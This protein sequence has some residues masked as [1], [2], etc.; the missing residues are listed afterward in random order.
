MRRPL[1][2]E[3]TSALTTS[4]HS[5]SINLSVSNYLGALQGD[6]YSGQALEGLQKALR[7]NKPKQDEIKLLRAASQLHLQR[8]EW[9]AAAALIEM[10]AQFSG[11]KAT[12]EKVDLWNQLAELRSER[13][14]D[15]EGALE[16]YEHALKLSPKHAN[17]RQAQDDLRK[18]GM[19][20]QSLVEQK[21]RQ[22]QHVTDPVEKARLITEI[23]ALLQKFEGNQ[24]EAERYFKEAIALNSRE[25]R[26]L[27]LYANLL[28]QQERWEELVSLWLN[29]AEVTRASEDKALFFEHAARLLTEKLQQR[30][31]AMA[32]YERVIAHRPGDRDA[33]ASLAEWF[34]EREAWDD[35]VELY[36]SALRSGAHA[37]DEQGALL[38]VGMI[39]WRKRQV[40]TDAEPYFARL[41]KA[42]PSHPAVLDFY[43]A[44]L[45][46]LPDQPRL[47]GILQDAQRAAVEP[48]QRLSLALKI[49][50]IAGKNNA[51]LDRSIDAWKVVLQ[52]D[53]TNVQAL[54]ALKTLYARAER[55]SALAELLKSML[56][57]VPSEDKEQQLSVLTELLSLY[58][59]RLRS[60]V[61]VAN[62]YNAI[63][64]IAPEDVEALSG[65][66]GAYERMGRWND[67][68]HVL[69]KHAEL[70]S[71]PGQKVSLLKSVADLS[72]EHSANLNQA[73][74]AL[75]QVLAVSSDEDVVAKLRDVFIKKRAWKDLYG[76][77]EQ[78]ADSTTSPVERQKY[79][80]EMANLAG[81]KLGNRLQAIALWKQILH[82]DAGA[83]DA[84]DAIEKLAEQEQDW[85]SLAEVLERRI[86]AVG[87]D[88]A[89]V[90]FLERLGVVYA[91]HLHAAD[92]ALSTWQRL[93]AIDPQSRRA[94][95]TVR[96]ALQEEQ[97]WDGLEALYASKNDWEG[98][99]DVLGTA[100]DRVSDPAIKID[101]SLRA[102]RVYEEK[103]GAPHRA[104]RSYERILSVDPD[105]ELAATALIPIYEQEEKWNRLVGVLRILLRKHEGGGSPQG[106]VELLRKLTLL[107]LDKLRDGE[108][109]LV[110]ALEAFQLDPT[111]RSIRE[112]LEQ[113]AEL[114]QQYEQLVGAYQEGLSKLT[115]PAELT[116]L[117]RRLAQLY[118]G[119]LATPS[120]AIPY[121]R[122]VADA[123]SADSEA[124]EALDRIYRNEKD[125]ESLKD[126][127]LRRL[128]AELNPERKVELLRELAT[129]EE[130]TLND[131]ES[132]AERFREILALDP[133]DVT[134]IIDLE[135]LATQSGRWK[136]LAE[137]LERHVE[138]A[139]NEADRFDLIMQR[140]RVFE[141]HL[142]EQAAA[143]MA[144]N[145]A[146]DMEPDHPGVLSALEQLATV[147]AEL[148]PE[149]DPTLERIYE[150]KSDINNLSRVLERSLTYASDKQPIRLRIA[151]LRAQQDDA[152]G[153]FIALRA[154]FM[155][156]PQ[157]VE[158]WEDL[159]QAA[160]QSRQEESLAQAYSQ[161]LAQHTLAEVD[162][163]ALSLKLAVLYDHALR[164]EK[165]AEPY[166]RRVIELDPSHDEAYEALRAYY[167]GQEQWSLLHELYQKRA[168]ALADVQEK[169]A[170]LLQ[171]SFL[172]EEILD[173]PAKAICNYE[174][175]LELD[176]EHSR[177]IRA[178]EALY[179]STGN[180]M[181][182]AQL[183]QRVSGNAQGQDAIDLQYQLG[184]LYET[185]L[186]N[187]ATAVDYYASVLAQQPTHLRAQ[188]ALERLVKEPSQRARVAE[189]LEP[190][191]E[192][193]GAYAELARILY[194]QL[195][196]LS[197]SASRVVM[198]SRIAEIQETKARDVRGAFDSYVLALAQD[199][200]DVRVRDELSRLAETTGR[201]QDYGQ[202]LQ[203]AVSRVNDNL[204]LH[205]ELLLELAKVWD[206][207]ENALKLSEQAYLELIRIDPDDR[208]F[209]GE[210]SRALVRIHQLL[211]DYVALGEDF[212]RLVTLEENNADRHAV[213]VQLSDL[214]E[215]VLHNAP[216][217]M[218]AYERRVQLDPTDFVAFYAWEKILEKEQQWNELVNVLRQEI[219]HQNDDVR[220]R[221]ALKH[222]ASVQEMFLKDIPGAIAVYEE[223]MERFSPEP[224]TLMSLAR[225]YETAERWDS[226]LE[227]WWSLQELSDSKEERVSLRFRAA[228]VLR[229]KLLNPGRAV[230]MYRET[231]DLASGHALTIRAL[232]HIVEGKDAGAR[233]SAAR[234]LVACYSADGQHDRL[235]DAL[236]VVAKSDDRSE[237]YGA[238]QRAARVVLHE[239]QS[240]ERAFEFMAQSARLA[241]DEHELRNALQEL[242][243]IA[244]SAGSWKQLLDLLK[245]LAPT[246]LDEEL[247]LYVLRALADIARM[248]L[249]DNATA[250][251]YYHVVLERVQDD[252]AALDA[253]EEL[254]AADGDH[255]GLL[256]VLKRKTEFATTPLARIHLLLRQADIAENELHQPDLAIEAYEHVMQESERGEAFE[257]LERL[258]TQRKRWVDLG[259]L[260]ERALDVG[261]GDPRDIR[262]KLA[263]VFLEHRNA[264][265][266]GMDHFSR[267]LEQAPDYTPSIDYLENL[268]R[269]GSH[270]GLAAGLLEPI[271]LVKLEWERLVQVMQAHCNAET[272]PDERMRLLERL[273]ETY[274]DHL[275]DLDG[276]MST[277]ARMF[278]LDPSNEHANEALVRLARVLDR[279]EQL[280]LIYEDV[281]QELSN[282][283]LAAELA[284]LAARIRVQRG[285]VADT[286]VNLLNRVLS[287]H[288]EHTEAFELLEQEFL[289]AASYEPLTELYSRRIDV[290]LDE[291]QQVEL[292]HRQ[293]RVYRDHLS[294]TDQAIRTYQRILEL[295]PEN[296]LA[297]R[298]LDD[299][300]VNAQRWSDLAEFLSWQADR[301]IGT[302]LEPQLR[303]RLAHVYIEKLE[304]PEQGIQVLEQMADANP[305]HQPTVE[306]L[307]FLVQQLPLRLRVARILERVYEATDQW[308]KLIAIYQARAELSQDPQEQIELYRLAAV[309]HEER[310]E[311][312]RLA[313]EAW[314][315]AYLIDSN[316]DAVRYELERL[317]EIGGLWGQLAAVLEEAARED[318]PHEERLAL[319]DTVAELYNTRINDPASAVRV[320]EKMLTLREPEDSEPILLRL[321]ELYTSTANLS[322]LASVFERRAKI[323]QD[324]VE[325]YELWLKAATAYETELHDDIQAVAAYRHA[326][327]SQP[328]N[329]NAWEALDRLYEKQHQHNELSEVLETRIRLE[330]DT[331]NRARL[332]FR[333]A[334]LYEM[335]LGRLKEAISNYLSVL[336]DEPSNVMAMERLL[337]TYQAEKMWPDY[338]E[339]LQKRMAVETDVSS[340]ALWHTRAA[341]ACQRELTNPDR[342][343]THYQSALNQ[344]PS[345]EPALQG[346]LELFQHEHLRASVVEL[347]VPLLTHQNRWDELAQLYE[348]QAEHTSDASTQHGLWVILA[349]LHEKSR[350]DVAKAYHARAKAVLLGPEETLSRECEELERLAALTGNWHGVTETYQE[351]IGKGIA[352]HMGILVYRRIAQV[353]EQ[354]LSRLDLAIS[355]LNE[356]CGLSEFRDEAC[357]SE[358]QRLYLQTEDWKNAHDILE[359]RFQRATGAEEKRTHLEAMSD[360]E[361]HKLGQHALALEHY[362]QILNIEPNHV[363]ATQGLEAFRND[364][365]LRAEALH[366][367]ENVYRQ[368][369]KLEELGQL[370][371][372]RLLESGQ[373]EAQL[374]LIDAACKLWEEE[375]QEPTR[376]FGY[377]QK[378]FVRDPS[379]ERLDH[380]ELLAET[381]QGW[382]NLEGLVEE[383]L[384]NHPNLE[385]SLQALF[386]ER[387]ANWYLNR[388]CN[389]TATDTLEK[390]LERLERYGQLARLLNQKANLWQEQGHA[391]EAA[392]VHERLALLYVHQNDLVQAC[393]HYEL[394][395]G[396]APERT[397]VLGA[398]AELYEKLQ[399]VPALV[400]TLEQQAAVLSSAEAVTAFQRIASLSLESLK[401]GARAEAAL[402]T[403]RALV[404]DDREVWN[405]LRALYEQAHDD[406]GVVEQLL[407]EEGRLTDVAAKV[408]RLTQA[409]QIAHSRLSDNHKAVTC[410]EQ[411]AALLPGDRA[412][413]LPLCDAYSALN[414]H[415]KAIGVL[416]SIVASFGNTRSKEAG[417]FH[418]RL[419]KVYEAQGNASLAKQHYEAAFK[420]DLGNVGV[421][422]DY[423]LFCFEQGDLDEAQKKFRA[424][425]LQRLDK[426]A[427]LSKAEV[428]FYLGEIASRQH[429]MPKAKNLYERALAEDRDL[430]QAKEA[431][432]RLS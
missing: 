45:T 232:H 156:E 104:F 10:L 344:D 336:D 86:E 261:L 348:M 390:V 249:K 297:A 181:G 152:A 108:L 91:E 226:L 375:L 284:L 424:L 112:T 149:I 216:K 46:S 57:H 154:A 188:E 27:L 6:P 243:A 90:S 215:N 342:A 1:Q 22:A 120:A 295:E 361:H 426:T 239:L 177:A 25:R 196:D 368:Q 385:A 406:Q 301:R 47:L 179:Q 431:L 205:K 89:A 404:P 137:L 357:L 332:R 138:L 59:D 63:L 235:V 416:E 37:N 397:E 134:A 148:C 197:D 351:R 40:V 81:S 17:T 214:Y 200:S 294:A 165:R 316:Q 269:Q 402:K 54:P 419:A 172:H 203:Q 38:Q 291:T 221:E 246:I 263:V 302:D 150:N 175:V 401:D 248:R 307:E 376:A 319:L 322:A 352:P 127:Y 356:A 422:K 100:A 173:E 428:Y 240:P 242:Q 410:Y 83:M 392:H 106:R 3:A 251:E 123:D 430:A 345:F 162:E 293:A 337:A 23:A 53:P 266:E 32:C 279:W 129:L 305:Q 413:L 103:I 383:A 166:Y 296:M 287:V 281:L 151:E 68:V 222:M 228:E 423:G 19:Q 84:L 199:A 270:V 373:P 101:L 396:L 85:V 329:Q 308:K 161:V 282:E 110:H 28:R 292:L 66:A 140:G 272:D 71:D 378:G 171:S 415:D 230:E 18:L 311:N 14:L 159:E 118:L 231:L 36:E 117:R 190:I 237:A 229:D 364:P 286:T 382:P 206:E 77:Y 358:L 227:A 257:P 15:A 371:E 412:V 56:E 109:A 326:T 341:Q 211:P 360:L 176:P 136:E 218:S 234:A 275:E 11:L 388:L 96:Q 24:A 209:V 115:D 5:Q 389:P 169:I 391:I 64:Q 252:H 403:A 288:P 131:A 333:L 135:R 427:G 4:E 80:R 219:E 189:I 313:M 182:L 72:I 343:F 20:W 155:A 224:T 244:E 111:D 12:E 42:N 97:D 105:N 321:S 194:V 377:C 289:R 278:R 121:L 309:L 178:L 33:M 192:S 346:A 359:K 13:L 168:A 201:N 367:L 268:V 223:I 193:Q 414:Q 31:R 285:L 163:M 255:E 280:A 411:A 132:A 290:V 365:E 325:R 143:L 30:E 328:E 16:A 114:S 409:G 425:L 310:G 29:A 312:Y 327:Q 74:A 92:K 217:A 126:V 369:G 247:S 41:R 362:I 139:D 119:P 2:F 145:Q 276:A 347:L 107:C 67:L 133:A 335:H 167:S 125:F 262:H 146:L 265:D 35:L 198:L 432:A 372:L 394:A 7:K 317:A 274:E 387:A 95:R 58:R 116:D 384:H 349:E 170:L 62:V 254:D 88:I 122:A 395:K 354:H 355:A 300:L 353:A 283:D 78:Q 76:L 34:T 130:R 264:P 314:S 213:L 238:L 386:C 331:L 98:L 180:W 260:Y 381:V 318:T 407:F 191:Y 393:E 102:A 65:L 379:I 87:T 338:V 39:H 363:T 417:Q 420:L 93:L 370:Y 340:L 82:E 141:D 320:Y 51:T 153:T 259:F 52:L 220:Q 195:E 303:H 256:Q 160:R 142:N 79:W 398:L 94:L 144:F 330:K 158:L 113:A 273:A 429:D 61:M 202:A 366:V 245:E 184:A 48:G 99:V 128:K 339:L 374:R 400:A 70:A 210:A 304:N 183:L 124:M 241:P 277:Y 298:A 258:Y 421:L 324:P 9:W 69:Q 164:S 207:R 186:S 174:A 147:H 55:W 50:D 399:N 73:V 418:H 157:T 267:L 250:R 271:L 75:Q 334:E 49:A 60:D 26:A 405:R 233:L 299:T 323:A 21:Q 44:T 315:K 380:L 253:L 8:G 43:E 187:P 212:E 236:M 350:G 208:D 408:E 225:L 185:R 306:S 204:G